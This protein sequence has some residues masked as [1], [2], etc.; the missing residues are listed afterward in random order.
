M[1]ARP[2]LILLFALTLSQLGCVAYERDD[3]DLATV[4]SA[5]SRRDGG[6]FSFAEAAAR[7]L[8]QNPE[9]QAAEARARAA[10]AASTVPLPVIGEWRGRNEAVGAMLD[11]IAMLG[12]GPRGAELDAADA[13]AALAATE[14]AVRRWRTL[15]E[16]AEAFRL[17][18]VAANLSAPELGDR[19][20]DAD[21]FERSGLA[22][23]VAAAML[24]AATSKART[25]RVELD[26]LRD[27]QEARL[28][29]LLGLP[30]TA[31]LTV[32]HGEEPVEPA[33]GRL[34]DLL[35]RP[36]L[37]VAAARFEVADRDFRKA[38]AAQYPSFTIGPNVSLRGDP[39]RAMA[40][41]NVPLGMQGLAAA[42]RER[43]EAARHEIEDALLEAR[44]E[45]DL[46]EHARR[47]ARSDQQ[48]A[49]L[50]LDARRTAF[51]A[52]RA[53][54]DVEP[55]AFQRYAAAVSEYVRAAADLRRAATT[56][57]VAEVRYAVAFGWP[58]APAKEELL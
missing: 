14:L 20:V 18:R 23:S 25:E 29:H 10:G 47:A 34:Q 24:R 17:H 13:R 44:R 55:D 26:R 39:L 54:L 21:A 8:R 31:T 22:S 35:A 9:V 57:A 1:S 37:A 36:D 52:A 3:A 50:M 15:A 40:M 7:A 38:V 32:L 16:V 46:A 51:V 43:R 41:L 56:S 28:R 19:A 49:L 53:A 12:L 58:A 30:A 5:V 33:D 2:I 45:A 4:A 11:P 48:T 27:D 42:A 6:A